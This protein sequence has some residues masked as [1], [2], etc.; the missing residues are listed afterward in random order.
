MGCDCITEDPRYND[1]VCYQRYC[2]KIEFAVI[3]KLDMDPSKTHITDIFEQFVYKL[4]V[5]RTW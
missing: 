4:Y 5:L 2:C 1:N 3:K